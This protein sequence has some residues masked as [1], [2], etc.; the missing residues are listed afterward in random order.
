MIFTNVNHPYAVSNCTRV[1]VEVLNNGTPESEEQNVCNPYVTDNYYN[2]WQSVSGFSQ[3]AYDGKTWY[4]REAS[5]NSGETKTVRVWVDVVPRSGMNKY[6]VFLKRASD[7]IAQAVS[8]GNYVLLDPWVNSPPTVFNETF[9]TGAF[10]NGTWGNL[11]ISRGWLIMNATGA[12]ATNIMLN[13]SAVG[14][15]NCWNSSTDS[16]S[17]GS[18]TGVYNCG[19]LQDNA[20]SLAGDDVWATRATPIFPEYVCY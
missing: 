7:T 9:D 4:S 12:N 6:Y 3:V 8:N 14:G 19:N 5:W 11:N 17:D 16:G 15:Q 13:T 18:G 2:D 1:T 10:I 20:I